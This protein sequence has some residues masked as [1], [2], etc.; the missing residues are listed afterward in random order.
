MF[1][2]PPIPSWE[3]LHPIVVHFPVALLLVSPLFV[4]LSLMCRKHRV[5]LAFAALLILLLGAGMAQ[6]ALMTGEA[7]DEAAERAG[8]LTK[9]AEAVLEDHEE[10]AE[11]TRTV[12]A[13]ITLGFGV[14]LAV[15]AVRGERFSHRAYVIG[16]AVV[17]VALAAGSIMLANTGHL[18]G[19]LVHEFG[20]RAPIA[21]QPSSAALNASRRTEDDD[22]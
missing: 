1:T 12:F 3:G 22:D 13:L 8:M 11:K 5:P 2:P 10:L 6:M 18:G 7:A 9:A 16:G 15:T 19:R 14:L 21:G 20:V 17:L 4:L